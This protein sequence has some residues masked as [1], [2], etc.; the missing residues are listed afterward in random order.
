MRRLKLTTCGSLH[1]LH[2]DVVNVGNY[3]AYEL[4]DSVLVLNHVRVRPVLVA[5]RGKKDSC[6]IGLHTLKTVETPEE[7]QASC[8]VTVI[9][10]NWRG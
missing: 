3:P 5:L 2:G 4:G 6:C 7:Q 1:H 9:E 10:R 8:S